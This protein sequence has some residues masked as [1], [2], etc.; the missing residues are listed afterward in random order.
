MSLSGRHPGVVTAHSDRN[1]VLR[2]VGGRGGG[3]GGGG[4]GGELGE[5]LRSKIKACSHTIHGLACVELGHPYGTA[6]LVCANKG[7]SLVCTAV[8][9]CIC[10]CGHVYEM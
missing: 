2:D 5:V 10:V 8:R 3:G 6:C 4:G 9:L 1:L 7:P